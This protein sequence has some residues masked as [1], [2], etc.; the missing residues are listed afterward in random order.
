MPGVGEVCPDLVHPAGVQ[1]DLHEA[2]PAKGR[3]EVAHDAQLRAGR[4]ATGVN[5]APWRFIGSP[6]H[7]QRRLQQTRRGWRQ[8]P[9]EAQILLAHAA[10]HKLQLGVVEAGISL[11]DEDRP[12]GVPVQAVHQA[13]LRRG[14]VGDG[15]A[16]PEAACHPGGQGAG[17]QRCGRVRHVP[18][19]GRGVADD[20]RPARRLPEHAEAR[21]LEQ[22]PGLG[23]RGPGRSVVGPRTRQGAP[24][25][26]VNLLPE[27]PH[28]RG[29]VPEQTV[30]PVAASRQYHPE[31]DDL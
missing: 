7:A 5:N 26:P 30:V 20:G 3:E 1:P 8:P 31:A 2:Q 17:G 25:W 22:H 12:R 14:V 6:D 4:R 16:R 11:R 18:G 13:V 28:S 24:A 15:K 23:P 10:C 9:A 19:S 27:G 21:P 29:Q